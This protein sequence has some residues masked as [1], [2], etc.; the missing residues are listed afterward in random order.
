MPFRFWRLYFFLT[1]KTKKFL[2]FKKN[3]HNF[4]AKF[5]EDYAR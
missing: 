5:G 3:I 4:E 1:K 2:T